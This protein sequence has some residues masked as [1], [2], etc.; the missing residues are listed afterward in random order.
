L[1]DIASWTHSFPFR[2]GQ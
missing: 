2:T 1:A